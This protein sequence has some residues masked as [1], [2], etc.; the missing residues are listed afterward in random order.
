MSARVLDTNIVSYLVRNDPLA[1]RYVQHTRGILPVVSFMTVAELYEWAQRHRW[2]PGRR[3][4]LTMTLGRCTVVE[5]SPDLCRRWAA[6]RCERRGRPISVPDAWI[7]STALEYDA[8]LVT[9]DA[10]DFAGIAGLRIIT[11]AS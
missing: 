1:A 4:R 5:S 11:E 7:A 8:E 9:H 2:G 6:V 10:G 3:A